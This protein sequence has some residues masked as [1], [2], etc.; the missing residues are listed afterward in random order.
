MQVPFHGYGFA[1]P[2]V[3]HTNIANV[4]GAAEAA[5]ARL[6]AVAMGMGAD[7][8]AEEKQKQQAESQLKAARA[9]GEYELAV[10]TARSDIA[11]QLQEGRITHDKAEGALSAAISQI[12]R[13]KM[14]GIDPETQARLGMQLEQMPQRAI[15]GFRPAISEARQGAMQADV[16]AN[17]DLMG[18]KAA[19]PGAN[20]EQINESINAMDGAGRAAF[21]PKWDEQKREFRERNYTNQITARLDSGENLGGLLQDLDGHYADKIQPELRLKLRDAVD[22][23]LLDQEAEGYAA[24]AM[25]AGMSYG[26]AIQQVRSKYGTGERGDKMLSAFRSRYA[27]ARLIRD[28]QERAVVDDMN[29]RAYE[30]GGFRA[31]GDDEIDELA[32]YAPDR[33]MRL[34][35]AKAQ[36]LENIAAGGAKFNSRTNLDVLSEAQA[37]IAR[38]EIADTAQLESLAPFLT[39]SDYKTLYKSV[40]NNKTVPMADVAKAF[41]ARKGDLKGSDP[42][43]WDEKTRGE[44]A[45]FNREIQSQVQENSRPQDLPLW[46]DSWFLSGGGTSDTVL[47]D[48]PNTLGEARMAGRTD[49]VPEGQKVTFE[50]AEAMGV[51]ELRRRGVPLTQ[52]NID[53]AR[54]AFEGKIGNE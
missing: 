2:Q 27:E 26:D 20:V 15:L 13:P 46:A 25:G 8:L 53:K 45:A 30:G 38:G 23:K 37:G 43:R 12:E 16:I 14:D 47:L 54:A 22:G 50:N 6:G 42:D 18:K 28:E 17:F 9:L 11:L 34:K 48:D 29:R 21:G 5:R 49:F 19:M 36:E 4:G 39:A 10:D 7:M 44:F 35:E 40:E 51:Q 24:Q 3:R 1:E 41:A 32:T 33:A 31:I 52:A